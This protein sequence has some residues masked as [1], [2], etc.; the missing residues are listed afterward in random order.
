M[1][2]DTTTTD[3][4]TAV[5][6][7]VDT[8]VKRAPA[9]EIAGKFLTGE[10]TGIEQD[11]TYGATLTPKDAAGTKIEDTGNVV[12]G[13]V[14]A[15]T[16]A[17]AA[18]AAQAQTADRFEA[19]TVDTAVAT[20][21]VA[22]AVQGVTGE[23][24]TVSEEAQV[25]AVTKEPTD[26]AVKGAP[27]AVTLDKAQQVAEVPDLEVT[28][29]MLVSGSAVDVN[30]AAQFAE[31]IK[32][33]EAQP[34]EEATVQGQLA[35]LMADFEGDTPPAWAAGALRNAS[36]AMAARG[37]SASSMAG[38]ALIQA[39]MEAALPIASQDAQTKASF[40]MTNLSNRQQRA[41]LAAE[42][43]AKFMGQKFD[44]DF[45]ARVQNAA[46]IADIAKT[47][48]TADV[49]IALENAQLA[50][51][52]DLANLSN[53]QARVMAEVAQ[54]ANLETQNLSNQQQAAVQNAKA[55]LDMDM[56]N[57]SNAQQATLF[58]SQSIVQGLLTDT[59]AVNAS[60]QF[61][62]TSQNQVNEFFAGLETQVNQF[63]ATQE[64]SINQFNADQEN[65]ISRFNAEMKNNREQFNATNRLVIDQANANWFK[66]VATQDTAAIN[67]ANQ[68]SVAN[69][70]N[71][72]TTAFNNYYQAERDMMEMA[73]KSGEGD[74]DRASSMAEVQL[75]ESVKLQLQD[76]K[77]SA[78]DWKDMG[79][80]AM[81]FISDANS[82]ANTASNIKDGWDLVTDFFN[83]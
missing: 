50:Q 56:A 35:N 27:E 12:T 4:T 44:Q 55:F 70:L 47:N 28:S 11:I 74:L 49:Q 54:I 58:R 64:N 81:D 75:Q 26:T 51:S 42:Q 43:R 53:K 52:V 2:E 78:E 69:L 22:Q 1:A 83:W 48:F 65:V 8:T 16:A 77:L 34:S 37:L 40:E 61:N 24:G 21:A 79:G 67:Y 38:Q 32:A 19:Q 33:A 20:P 46:T 5:D 57:L 62:A 60:K 39:A 31:E 41:M 68:Q 59:A 66:Q 72:T 36:A 25:Q 10:E 13:D 7:T 80:W 45:Q 82:I 9:S 29:D 3:E 18:P 30:Q 14:G 73:W 63:N 17:Q 6:E 71:F 15:G 76:K 23:Q